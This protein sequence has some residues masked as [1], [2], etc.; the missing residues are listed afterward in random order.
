MLEEVVDRSRMSQSVRSRG[1][2]GGLEASTRPTFILS[3]ILS[4]TCFPG[5][6][7]VR[8]LPPKRNVT[9]VLS[10]AWL[11]KEFRNNSSGK[12]HRGHHGDEYKK[13]A[14]REKYTVSRMTRSFIP[15]ALRR[16]SLLLFSQN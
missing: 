15:M 5:D 2:K 10:K 4:S 6:G 11:D 1:F 3:T 8:S 16:E 14:K 9:C 13:M 12:L 7:G